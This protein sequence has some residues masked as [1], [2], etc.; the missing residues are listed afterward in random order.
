M[1]VLAATV[2]L[3]MPTTAQ[4][5][6]ATS[7][8][9]VS[10]SASSRLTE[11]DMDMTA[12]LSLLESI[13]D[14]VLLAGDEATR[15]W[16][17]ENH[18]ESLKETR[19][20]IL[21][22]TAAIATLIATTAIP[23]AKILKIKKLITAGGGVAKVVKLYWGASFNYEKIRAIGGAAG[24]LALEIVGDTAIKKGCF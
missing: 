4:A 3:S 20:S 10:I 5:A 16:T 14:S 21:A 12:A 19:G 24:A 18:P 2:P 13:P 23:A 15:Q 7:H 22:C 17:K 11:N 9:V 8:A 1:A 6:S